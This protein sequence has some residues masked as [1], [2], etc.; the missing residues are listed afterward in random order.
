MYKVLVFRSIRAEEMGY[1]VQ[2][3]HKNF[4]ADAIITIIT[5]PEYVG[6]MESIPGV[7]NVLIYSGNTFKVYKNLTSEIMQLRENSFDLAVIPTSGN[8]VSYDNVVQFCRKVFNP[9][10]TYNYMY[11][12]KFTKVNNSIFINLGKVMVKIFS[13]IITIPLFFLYFIGI[14]IFSASKGFSRSSK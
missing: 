14:G 6:P 1:V 2:D 13:G 3:V 12:E 8:L 5:R 9:A 7:K 4:G 10:T 11:P